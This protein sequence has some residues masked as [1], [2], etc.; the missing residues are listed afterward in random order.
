MV[1]QNYKQAC[2]FG[3]TG[4]IGR[5]ISREL[6]KKGYI[7]KAAT[8]VPE[9]AFF[10]K[11]CGNVGQIV[12][13][14]C[15]YSDEASLNDAIKGCDLVVN[16]V[17]ILYE[18][19]KDTFAAT[20]TELPRAI[21][22]AC[23]TQ[24]VAR[25]IHISAL[26]CDHTE[27][28]YGKSKYAGEQA[29]LENFPAATILRP[30]LVF[31]AEDSFFNMFASMSVI[32]P[33]LPLIGG[34]HTKF[35]PVYV[36]DVADAAIRCAGD[37]S[38]SGHTYELGGPEILTFR[39]IYE[40]L[41]EQTGRKKMLVS[42]PWGFA[43]C[44]GRLLSLLPHPP[45]TADQVLSLKTDNTVSREARTFKDLNLQPTAMDA[46][47]PSYLSRYRPGGRFGDKKRA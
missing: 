39:Q 2:I 11:T 34:G 17:G 41:F 13:Y 14:G 40:R 22:K 19:G 18:K 42:L 43:Q 30:S 9:R 4:F 29:I 25:F 1:T 24:G 38:T 15:T 47:L 37:D 36:G 28:K 21:A 35:Q 44:Q 8:R 46:V 45:L 20:H 26:G 27:S 12:P 31:G 7:I 23:K 16:C 3:A 6:A 5:Q 32:L 10:L 33:V